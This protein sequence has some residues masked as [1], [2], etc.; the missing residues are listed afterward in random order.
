[1]YS[2]EYI[3]SFHC[4][5]QGLKSGCLACKCF[6]YCLTHCWPSLQE[7]YIPSRLTARNMAV[8]SFWVVTVKS[9][10][11][12]PQE[13]G[14][15]TLGTEKLLKS[16]LSAS[17]VLGITGQWN[18]IHAPIFLKLH[19]I[20]RPSTYVFFPFHLRFELSGLDVQVRATT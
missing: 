10:T 18:E 17:L 20:P 13:M 2:E 14:Q 4:G 6:P 3:L 8:P 7:F 11:V 9:C 16:F 15:R 19:Q 5:S 1:M 12:S